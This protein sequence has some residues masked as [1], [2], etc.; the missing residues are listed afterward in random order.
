MKQDQ[1]QGDD[2][3]RAAGCVLGVCEDDHDGADDGGR[4]GDDGSADD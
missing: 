1:R 2:N 3:H 4:S